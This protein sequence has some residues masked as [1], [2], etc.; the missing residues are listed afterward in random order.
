MTDVIYQIY[1]I[2]L[3]PLGKKDRRRTGNRRFV[4]TC[5]YSTKSTDD[6]QNVTPVR[7]I[8]KL[9][10]VKLYASFRRGV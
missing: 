2:K 1:L 5:Y 7:Y 4:L 8:I 9:K 6:K 10:A 3:F